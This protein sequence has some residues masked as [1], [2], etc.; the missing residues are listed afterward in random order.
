MGLNSYFRRRFIRPA[1]LSM[2]STIQHLA[3]T[4]PHA[5]GDADY[6]LPAYPGPQERH[7]SSSLPIAPEP[8]RAGYCT[9]T[10]SY[11]ASG[12]DDVTTMRRLLTESGAPIEGLGRILEFGVAGGRL[13]RHL[14]E[15]ADT[16]EI[17]GVDC[18]ASAI[19]WCKEHLSP[20]F[21]FATTGI[22]P[23]L[24]FEDRSFGL[25]VAGSVWTHLDDLAEAWALEMR[26]IL[27]PDGRFYFTIND[28]SAVAF[29]E[30]D[31]SAEDRA[32]YIERIRPNAWESWR[33]LLDSHAGYR[34][35]ARGEA[36]MATMGRST[37]AHVLWDVDH[38]VKRFGPGW[39]VCSITPRA[40]GHQTGVLLAKG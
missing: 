6:T 26:R 32:R 39:R 18:W 27:R 16:Q 11:L 24:P 10:E 40:Y 20:P 30:G 1:L 19:L 28:R 12:R 29:F 2:T 8:F 5:A 13:I 37:E 25:V 14:E 38:L 21:H 17:W 36:Q 7:T 23:H 35:F 33:K 31:G 22:S 3:A 4:F 15:L 34:R 9:S